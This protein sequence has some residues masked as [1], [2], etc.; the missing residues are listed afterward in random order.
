[1][2]KT[3]AQRAVGGAA[4]HAPVRV[5]QAPVARAPQVA[6]VSRPVGGAPVITRPILMGPGATAPV[7]QPRNPLLTSGAPGSGVLLGGA[8]PGLRPRPLPITRPIVLFN[9]YLASGPY[10]G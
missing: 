7:I 2:V 9:P 6:A 5:P 10:L 1:P 4:A 8:L 3:F